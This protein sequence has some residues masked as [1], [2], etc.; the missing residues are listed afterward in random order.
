M[1]SEYDARYAATWGTEVGQDC[2]TLKISLAKWLGTRLLFL[3]EHNH[4]GTAQL[5][6]FADTMARHGHALVRYGQSQEH[7]HQQEAV[8]AMRWVAEHFS[9]LWH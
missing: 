5:R 6:D 2:I 9:S 3:A 4:R 1:T 8:I 7:E